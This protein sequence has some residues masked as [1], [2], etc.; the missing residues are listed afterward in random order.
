MS[1]M[2]VLQNIQKQI[3]NEELKNKNET[4]L[5][6]NI[7]G[8]LTALSWP[9]TDIKNEYQL[10]NGDRPDFALVHPDSQEPLVFIELK[11]YGLT[12]LKNSKEQVKGYASNST[13][14][15][16]V[17]TDVKT[18]LFYYKGEL[19]FE[20]GFSSQSLTKVSKQLKEF[21]EPD[22]V[23]R[24]DVYRSAKGA[25]E[26]KDNLAKARKRIPASWRQ[27]LKEER[28][29]SR[30]NL[31]NE[32]RKKAGAGLGVQLADG[33][34]VDFLRSLKE[35]ASKSGE[36]DS[37]T[38]RD[39]GSKVEK[40]KGGGRSGELVILGKSFPCKN[41]TDAMV[42][43]FKELERR[44]PG[45]YQR[46]YNDPR[47]WNRNRTRRIIAQDARGLYDSDNPRYE[48]AYKQLGGGW[49][50]ATYNSKQTIEKNIR[51]AAEV[52]GLEFGKDITIHTKIDGG[53]S[54]FYSLLQNPDTVFQVGSVSGKLQTGS[55][56]QQVFNLINESKEVTLGTIINTIPRGKAV[57]ALRNL[58]KRKII[59]IK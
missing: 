15:L 36:Q 53:Q 59:A 14:S 4:G 58:V 23:Y 43:V 20:T 22:R 2:K 3:D 6:Q 13:V 17:L 30:K 28:N 26:K 38:P 48:K 32:L 16:I 44:E 27:F 51:I 56:R 11:R 42:I 1:L 7:W 40:R 37:P 18:W 8:I 46:F 9:D 21:L 50:I 55:V 31:I 5:K 54:K 39:N 29:S 10:S 33:D 12:R 19:A 41:P 45:F 24:G 57:P 49:F 35:P 25:L 34:V 47:N 52:A